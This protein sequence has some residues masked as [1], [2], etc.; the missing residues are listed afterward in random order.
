M[1]LL[2]FSPEDYFIL[3]LYFALIL[4]IG[5]R[6]GRKQGSADFLLAGRRLTLPFFVMTLVSSWYGGI[7][8]VGEF[9]F[10][11]GISN[12]V[13]Q[14]LPYYLFALVFAWLLAERIRATN[15]VTIPD[16]LNEVYDRRTALLGAILTFLLTTPAP[17]ILMVGI[18]L[19]VCTG[20][21]L[22][23]CIVLGTGA[24]TVYLFSGGFSADV[25]T[26]VAEF[27]VMFLGFGVALAVAASTLGGPEYLMARLPPLH[28]TWHGG[29]SWQFIVIWFLIALWT[30]VD[31]TFH[32]R[33]YAAKDGKTARRGILISIPIWFLFDALT[34]TTGL[35][36]RAV[37]PDL[38]APVMAY[39]AFAEAVLPP[40]AKGLFVAGMLATVMSTLNTMTFIS[41]TTLGR[42]IYCRLRSA[43]NVD[44]MKRATRESIAAHRSPFDFPVSCDPVSYRPLV[45]GGY[46]D[47]PGIARP[48]RDEL[49]PRAADRRADR[50]PLDDLRM[51]HFHALVDS[52]LDGRRTGDGNLP[53]WH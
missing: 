2:T 10:R 49:F 46:F 44:S 20:W 33:C 45:R 18:L 39:P 15:L 28:L 53:A 30:L 48:G 32:Q 25:H 41:A 3:A 5:F 4:F 14:G 21:P 29:N 9:S 8:G 35:Y 36:A 51:V 13:V 52:G 38:D 23:W 6:A 37:L 11:Y 47:H 24:T 40:V 16:R 19:Q 31:P 1:P 17:Y 50:F 43:T 42:D 7:L 34:A 22:L 12:W 26:D 27:A